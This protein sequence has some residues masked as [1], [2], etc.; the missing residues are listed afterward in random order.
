MQIAGYVWRMINTVEEKISAHV[1][2]NLLYIAWICSTPP[3]SRLS[4]LSS[5]HVWLCLTEWWTLQPDETHL[6]YWNISEDLQKQN[7]LPAKVLLRS[8]VYKL[9]IFI[10]LFRNAV[11]EWLTSFSDWGQIQQIASA[12]SLVFKGQL[13]SFHKVLLCQYKPFAELILHHT[14]ALNKLH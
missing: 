14:S 13:Y 2:G 8:L 5:P 12:R 11:L 4:P 6:F 7:N 9:D 3:L 1:K 10:F